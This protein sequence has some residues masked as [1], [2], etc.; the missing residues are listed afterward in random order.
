MMLDSS[1]RLIETLSKISPILPDIIDDPEDD[2]EY[3]NKLFRGVPVGTSPDATLK[4]TL[5]SQG[6]AR[7]RGTSLSYSELQKHV[8]NDPNARAGVTSWSK[9]RSV[10][11]RFSRHRGIIL[12]IDFWSYVDRI[13]GHPDQDR[14]SDEHEVLIRDEVRGALPT[15][16]DTRTPLWN[17]W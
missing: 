17:S 2:P 13:V 3:E 7:P 4:Y 8:Y 12:E 1:F 16:P 10:A 5:A 9:R 14:Y 11:K 15:D 6:I